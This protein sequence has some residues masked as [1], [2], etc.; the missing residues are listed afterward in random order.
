MEI[1]DVRTNSRVEALDITA[2]VQDAVTS[3]GVTSGA[4]VVCAAH[5]TAGL[6][7]NENADP[8]VMSDLMETLTRLVPRE[9]PYAHMEGNSDAHLKS[10]LMG[11]SVVI[12]VE[13]GRLQLG[14]WQ[15]VYFCEFDG[16]RSR[17]VFVQVLASR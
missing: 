15:G 13:E 3:L 6:T 4:A 16:P 10:S 9:G 7:I 2:R 8:D 5:T 11:H 17:R 1:I 14:T 12:P